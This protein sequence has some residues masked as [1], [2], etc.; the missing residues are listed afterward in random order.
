MSMLDLSSLSKA[1]NSLDEV[2]EACKQEPENAFL[3]DASIQRFE[4][5]YELCHKMLKRYLEMSEPSNAT[6]DSM[7]FADLIRTAEEKQLIASNWKT[8][9]LFRQ[10]RNLTSHTYDKL[11]AD[12]VSEILPSFLQEAHFLL[13]QLKKNIN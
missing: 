13:Q 9:V 11:K 5:T 8:W 12:Q 1:I 3:Q 2:L 10:A 6:I 7:S 4:Y